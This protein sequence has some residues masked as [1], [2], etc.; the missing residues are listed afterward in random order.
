[1]IIPVAESLGTELQGRVLGR[2]H[3]ALT[4]QMLA[5]ARPGEIVLLDFNDVELVTG[6]WVNAMIVPLFRWV[7]DEQ[8]DLFPVFSRA[9]DD[10]LDDLQLVAE[11]NHQCYLLGNGKARPPRRAN[12]VGSL[13]PG[14]QKTLRAMLD[15]GE[16][17]GAQ[18]E[19]QYRKEK[20]K[21]T[22]WNNRLKDLYGKRLLM[23]RKQGREQLY[24]PVIQDIV[25]DG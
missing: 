11:W 3:F 1:M 22:A 10:W 14:Q 12:L 24:S 5:D 15:I 9:D 8:I 20:A 7:S 4:C 17:T 18:L 2:K 13:D 16:A 21:A 23:R 6:S 19:R 25:F